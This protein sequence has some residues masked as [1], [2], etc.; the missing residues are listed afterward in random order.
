MSRCARERRVLGFDLVEISSG[1]V[2]LPVD[3]LVAL[4]RRVQEAGLRAK[5]EVGIQFGAGGTSSRGARSA[6]SNATSA[7]RSSWR[8]GTWRRARA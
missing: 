8:S 2:T 1:F 4:T 6:G 3:D 5:P 7:T